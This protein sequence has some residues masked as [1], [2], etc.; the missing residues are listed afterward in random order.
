M[1]EVAEETAPSVEPE[2]EEPIAQ[3]EPTTVESTPTVPETSA[4]PDSSDTTDNL[5]EGADFQ[6][7]PDEKEEE[8][9]E[10]PQDVPSAT[11]SATPTDLESLKAATLKDLAPIVGRLDLEPTEKLKTIMEMYESTK[12]QT[13]LKEAHEAAISLPDDTARAKALLDLVH[14]I[15][16]L[17]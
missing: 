4:E 1:P 2:Q 15:D 5:P 9:I 8:E 7:V 6:E 13:L 16:E 11:T 10:E 3:V 12:D 17:V 14:K